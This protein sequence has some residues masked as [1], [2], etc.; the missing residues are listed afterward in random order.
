M[1]KRQGQWS[2]SRFFIVLASAVVFTIVF[3]IP[4]A[5]WTGGRDHPGALVTLMVGGIVVYV[6]ALVVFLKKT[7]SKTPP[8]AAP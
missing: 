3:I 6:V 2:W 1:A 8:N 7:T 5:L 4:V